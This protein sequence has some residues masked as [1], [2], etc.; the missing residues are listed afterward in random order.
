VLFDR[1]TC[2]SP[3]GLIRPFIAA[4][5][6]G[7]LGV[8]GTAGAVGVAAIFVNS[9]LC[10]N[11]SPYLSGEFFWYATS[12]PLIH[13]SPCAQGQAY[14]KL[15]SDLLIRTRRFLLSDV[16][17]WGILNY[18]LNHQVAQTRANKKKQKGDAV[19]HK[20]QQINV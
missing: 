10:T 3:S 9:W 19:Y 2:D 1:K 4:T 18:F 11:V 20:L 8:A 16:A 7:W 12:S 13:A 14:P 17:M 5:I 15:N 6:T